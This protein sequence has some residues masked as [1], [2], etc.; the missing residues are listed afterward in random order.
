MILS[1]ELV[2]SY[3]EIM[4]NPGKYDLTLTPFMDCWE[5]S[6][7]CTPKHVLAKQYT[8]YVATNIPKVVLYIIMDETL[9]K[10]TGIS[11]NGDLGYFLTM[12]AKNKPNE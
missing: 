1:E 12:T 8:D 11:E 6:D 10:H 4:T 2:N 5:V 7:I 9:M 3:K